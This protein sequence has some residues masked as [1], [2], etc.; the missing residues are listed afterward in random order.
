MKKRFA[1]NMR[2]AA[3]VLVIAALFTLGLTLSSCG[4][5]VS[6]ENAVTICLVRH[7]EATS[8]IDGVYA[9][10]NTESHLTENGK[11]QAETLGKAISFIS[12]D[13]AYASEMTRTQETEDIILEN[14]VNPV[15]QVEVNAGFDEI[16]FGK[17]DGM[18][19]ADAQAAF[20]DDL[21][22]TYDDADFSAPTGGESANQLANRINT[23]MTAVVSASDNAG[24]TILVTGHSSAGWW[25]QS[26]WP[27]KC[28][29]SL[30]NGSLTVLRYQDGK[31]GLL[32]YNET[33]FTDIETRYK[34]TVR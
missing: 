4:R 6:G 31:W 27:D 10:K 5:Q 15:P 22:G 3:L 30:K 25:L 8:N 2:C 16:D 32:L 23:A 28:S 21:F 34:E 19:S 24:K 1:R 14:N 13:R 20:G 33:D 11:A 26:M 7:G 18:T 9:G 17:A 29:D 12:F